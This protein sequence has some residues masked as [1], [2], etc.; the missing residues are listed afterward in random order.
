MDR[1]L[2]VLTPEGVS[3]LRDQ[4]IPAGAVL[5]VSC[6]YLGH[7]ASDALGSTG[8]NV[9]CEALDVVSRKQIYVGRGKH[10][11]MTESSDVKGAIRN[12][13]KGFPS[14]GRTGSV[15][16]LAEFPSE[17]RAPAPSTRVSDA[18]GELRIS[19]TGSAFLIDSSGHAVTNA[20]VVAG[21]TR[22]TFDSR[23]ASVLREDRQNDLALLST[24][25][26][27]NPLPLRSS[28]S[29]RSGDEVVAL[30][31]PLPSV[32]SNEMNVTSG[33][34]SAMSG[35][36]GDTRFF[37]MTA[38]IQPGNSGGP[39]ID[40]N[41]MVVGVVVSKLD[42]V[43]VLRETG[44]VPQN[45]NFALSLG[46]LRSFLDANGIR[47]IAS[48]ASTPLSSADIGS[49]ARSAVGRVECWTRE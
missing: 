36:G 2:T 48:A 49:I 13:F 30:G 34:I 23:P 21:C 24:S 25:R 10:T 4:R 6:A 28:A 29:V 5:L 46:T 8:A 27:V 42:V 32:L 7:S 45:V 15:S 41:G 16:M 35:L 26:S 38:P 20:H 17:A 33:T 18:T 1:G 19:S 9:S 47:Y 44:D 39:L 12:A 31:Y 11:G 22:V 14:N 43:K 3:Y 40:R 37:Q